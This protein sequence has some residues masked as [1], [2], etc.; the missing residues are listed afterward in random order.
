MRIWLAII[1]IVLFIIPSCQKNVSNDKN[2]NTRSQDNVLNSNTLSKA[3]YETKSSSNTAIPNLQGQQHNT[4][5][6]INPRGRTIEERIKPP[7]GFERIKVE[8]GSFA[9]Y[10]RTLPLKPHGSKVKYYDGREKTYNVY[11]AV[12]DMDIGDKDLQQC[13]DAVIRLRAE[14]LYKQKQYDRIHFN[15]T[16]GFNA[17]FVKWMQGYRIAVTGNRVNWVK[18][19]TYSDGYSTFRKY[20]DIVFSYAGTL[21]LSKE[22]KS[23]M[24]EDMEIGDVFIQGG[25]PGHCVIVV[26]M[27]M[28]PETGEK[29]FMLA[30][31]YMP[32]Q[33]IHI[34]KNLQAPQISP[35]YS[36]KFGDTLITPEW[37][38][39]KTDLKRFS[40]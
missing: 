4:S 40:N 27:A 33:D 29:L 9:H 23:V 28:H 5:S 37:T 18:S 6:I 11:E 25:S 16:N 32:A 24:I 1:I 3:P 19:S 7:E 21:S 22:M 12:I 30:Q 20:L 34:L 13:A 14:Y 8:E 26:D 2:S 35:W 17:Q 15:F 36:T 38:F 39:K 31:S 10:L